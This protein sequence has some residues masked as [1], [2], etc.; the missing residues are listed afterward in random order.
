MFKTEV[1]DGEKIRKDN[2]IMTSVKWLTQVKPHP[3]YLLMK[4]Y[5]LNPNPVGALVGI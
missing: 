3:I 2:E 5:G 4:K 1:L